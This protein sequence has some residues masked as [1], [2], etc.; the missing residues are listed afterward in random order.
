MKKILLVQGLTLALFACLIITGGY[1]SG[2]N[3]TWTFAKGVSFKYASI[4]AEYQDNPWFKP[5]LDI[6]RV[7]QALVTLVPIIELGIYIRIFK[8][9]NESSKKNS[10]A[11]TEALFKHRKQRNV[12]TLSGQFYCFCLETFVGILGNL[13]LSNSINHPLIDPSMYPIVV[14]IG[15]TIE[16]L[17]KFCASPD[18]REFYFPRFFHSTFPQIIKAMEKKMPPKMMS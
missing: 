2:T 14:I 4:L 11:L 15:S 12:L 17:G 5:G 1:L 16:T 7:I 13:M 6:I 10:R 9:L 8:L 18:M 3:M